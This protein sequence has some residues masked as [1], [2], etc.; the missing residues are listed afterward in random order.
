MKYQNA[1]NVQVLLCLPQSIL[2]GPTVRHYIALTRNG[3]RSIL[4]EDVA[5]IMK[6]SYLLFPSNDHMQKLSVSLAYNF[7]ALM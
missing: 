6:T 7:S 3:D 5:Y 1:I 4:Y 2:E